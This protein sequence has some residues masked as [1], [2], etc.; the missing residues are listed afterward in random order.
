MKKVVSIQLLLLALVLGFMSCSDSK[1]MVVYVW[2]EPAITDSID[3]L[4]VIKTAY[5]VYHAPTLS[6]DLPKGS[7]LWVS[8][9]L[10]ESVEKAGKFFTVTSLNY[11]QIGHAAVQM[12][13]GELPE[14]DPNFPANYDGYTDSIDVARLYSSYIDNTLFF[15]FDQKAPEGQKFEYVLYCNSDSVFNTI[16]TFYIKAKRVG[17]AAGNNK[18]ILTNYGF[19]M[20]E[21]LQSNL[22]SSPIVQFNVK[23]KI[24][25]INGK[26]VYKS[27]K[28]SPLKW[29]KPSSNRE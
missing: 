1:P 22:A 9:I 7:H 17:S 12:I 18:D 21:F 26:D 29:N 2:D 24:G 23:Y 27:F 3:N 6:A 11:K 15:G 20:T 4:P 14:S 25:T 16:P 5:G 8:F 19:D 13:A 10:D 28:T